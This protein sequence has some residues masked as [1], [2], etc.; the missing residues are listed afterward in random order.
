M[1]KIDCENKL[2]HTHTYTNKQTIYLHNRLTFGN[3]DHFFFKWHQVIDLDLY[4]M[5]HGRIQISFV[6]V[7]S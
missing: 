4:Q 1:I 2:Q 3:N 6:G 7:D 5:K